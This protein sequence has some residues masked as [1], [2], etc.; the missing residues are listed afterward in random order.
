[1]KTWIIHHI[2]NNHC[3]Y[4]TPILNT[5]IDSSTNKWDPCCDDYNYWV[6]SYCFEGNLP[7]KTWLVISVH[8][9]EIGL[10][11]LFHYK[12][13]AK[14]RKIKVYNVYDR[15]DK[16]YCI[17]SIYILYFIRIQTI[18]IVVSR[19]GLLI[20]LLQFGSYNTYNYSSQ[21]DTNRTTYNFC[22]P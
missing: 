15:D 8:C 16:T 20:N 17:I 19:I 7:F 2:P 18:F 4:H 6:E 5:Q 11:V 1:M 3:N 21:R 12:T 9:V 13:R 14:K 10:A 22:A